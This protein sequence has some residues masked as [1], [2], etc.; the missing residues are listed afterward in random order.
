M[1]MIISMVVFMFRQDISL[2]ERDYYPRGQAY[3]EM[4]RSVNNTVPYA[5]DITAGLKS[6]VVHVS[7]PDFFRPESTEGNIHLYHRVSD[8]N[9]RYAEL[10]LDENCVFS[11]PA[12]G[13]QGRYILKI[14][15]Q[16]DGVQYYTEKSILIE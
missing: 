11:Y 1:L 9:D 16:Q 2:V 5:N 12:D 8:E 7:F 13:L 14:S 6:N 4:I 10:T 3:Q 15:W